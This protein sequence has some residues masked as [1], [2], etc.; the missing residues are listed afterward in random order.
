MNTRTMFMN[1]LDATTQALPPE[2]SLYMQRA[3]A[4]AIQMLERFSGSQIE[5]IPTSLQLLDE[6]ID[7]MGRGGALPSAARVLVIA[8]LGQMFLHR[9]GGYWA[10]QMQNQKQNLGVVCPVAGPEENISRFINVAEQ[11][12]R[13]LALGIS[14]SLTFFYLTTSVDLKGRS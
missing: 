12:S 4:Q 3:A 8:F 11:I 14:E 6:W 7:R 10:T 5:Y 2:R 1:T 13:R 9:H